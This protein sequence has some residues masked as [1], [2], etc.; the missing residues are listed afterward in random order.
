M[1]KARD[2]VGLAGNFSYIFSGLAERLYFYQVKTGHKR[3]DS[4]MMGMRVFY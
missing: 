4:P 3:M 1:E 2:R